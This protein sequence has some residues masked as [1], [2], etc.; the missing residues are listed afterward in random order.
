MVIVMTGRGHMTGYYLLDLTGVNGHR[1]L[2]VQ[3]NLATCNLLNQLLQKEY[4]TSCTYMYVTLM[5]LTYVYCITIDMS[6]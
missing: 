1:N 5:A 3:R 6:A 2:T 4:L